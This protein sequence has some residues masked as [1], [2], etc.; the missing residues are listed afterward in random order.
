MN[1]KV[2]T[3]EDVL[4]FVAD[5]L[6]KEYGVVVPDRRVDLDKLVQ[7][8]SEEARKRT[9]QT[10]DACIALKW[11]RPVVKGS[12]PPVALTQLGV[13]AYGE[14][15]T[16]ERLGR[17]ERWL[18]EQSVVRGM[19]WGVVLQLTTLIIAI[20]ALLVAILK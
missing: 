2:E 8:M 1:P 7:S 15:V 16:S 12:P 5:K 6:A 18:R 17:L 14:M 4:R 20:V 9:E 19:T 3:P 10:I 13:A 11:I